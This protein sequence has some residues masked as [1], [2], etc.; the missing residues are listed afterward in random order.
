MHL[1][2]FCFPGDDDDDSSSLV[3]TQI[4]G[5]HCVGLLPVATAFIG[6]YSTGRYSLFREAHDRE[7]S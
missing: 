7:Q 3:T 1:A 4:D 5:L 6:L 2:S